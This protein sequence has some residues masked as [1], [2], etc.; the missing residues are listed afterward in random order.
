MSFRIGDEPVPG[1][2]GAAPGG[3]I[4]HQEHAGG[5]FVE[6]GGEVSSYRDAIIRELLRH[7]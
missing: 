7:C 2:P 4:L 6:G 1:T 3:L 5:E